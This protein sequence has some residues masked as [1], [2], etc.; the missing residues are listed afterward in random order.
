MSISE[1]TIHN[2]A[3]T[4]EKRHRTCLETPRAG[5]TGYGLRVHWCTRTEQTLSRKQNSTLLHCR[6]WERGIGTEVHYLDR[7]HSSR[8][9][10]VY[11]AAEL[12]GITSVPHGR[13]VYGNCW[14]TKG[15]RA[16]PCGGVPRVMPPNRAAE[17]SAPLASPSEG[18][19]CR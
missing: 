4:E 3:R 1:H 7:S 2:D 9:R 18:W 19:F 11:Y 15:L 17:H 14:L 6:A 8:G 5:S 16:R 12:G 13:R 10:L